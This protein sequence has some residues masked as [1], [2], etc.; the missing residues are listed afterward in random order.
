[1]NEVYA[2]FLARNLPPQLAKRIYIVVWP[3]YP[4]IQLSTPLVWWTSILLLPKLAASG[5]YTRNSTSHS[6]CIEPVTR[7]PY[8]SF[9]SSYRRRTYTD[10]MHHIVL[11]L[12]ILIEFSSFLT[13]QQNHRLE[14][15]YSLVGLIFQSRMEQ[16]YDNSAGSFLGCDL[17]VRCG[18]VKGYS[19]LN[20]KKGR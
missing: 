6:P 4:S 20:E 15:S 7:G 19:S 9:L 16:N 2:D 5:K 14:E 18:A 11:K 17:L 1:M 3:S 13:K 12:S 10:A 8:S